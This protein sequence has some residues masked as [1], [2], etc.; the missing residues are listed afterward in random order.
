MGKR[1]SIFGLIFLMQSACHKD[2][3]PQD[4]NGG[5]V[6]PDSTA[7]LI[8]NEGNF[9]WGNASIGQY[10]PDRKLY[11]DGLYREANGSPLGDVIQEAHR[12]N[13]RYYLVMNGSNALVICDL[14]W[15]EVGRATGLSAPRH[16]V[17]WRQSL[18]M[19][20]LYQSKLL[21]LDLDGA[22]LQEIDLD[23]PNAQL[24]VWHD[25][26]LIYK[27]DKIEFLSDPSA[28]IGTLTTLVGADLSALCI[29][30]EALI[31]ALETS[32]LLRWAHRDS[33]LR[34]LTSLS[35]AALK[36]APM[37]NQNAFFAYDGDSIYR[38]APHSQPVKQALLQISC[39]NY[40]GFDYHSA[41]QSLYLFDALSFV[42]PHRVRRINALTGV[43]ED[44]FEAGALPNGVVRVW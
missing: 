11:Q 3:G 38:I 20:D 39:Q 6:V 24:A 29:V 12:I 15:K 40:Y 13:D 16:L 25:E 27:A 37:P 5:S 30:D 2:Y 36:L 26:L 34:S 18:W 22:L 31:L 32:D 33:T 42:Q 7:V 41:T 19:S 44:D 35:D 9:Q 28:N 21:Q 1:I 17:Y 43:V 4:L 8:V 23:F 10:N 14:D